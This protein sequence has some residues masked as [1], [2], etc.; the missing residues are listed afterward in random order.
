ML[1]EKPVS[2]GRIPES[3]EKMQL[4]EPVAGKG[5]ASLPF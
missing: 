1:Q 2:E 4:S 3:N 5:R